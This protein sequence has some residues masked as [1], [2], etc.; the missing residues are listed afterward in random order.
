MML[1]EKEFSMIKEKMDKIDQRLHKLY[2][3]WHA[4]YGNANTIEECEE[5]RNFYK[6][7]LDKYESKYRILYQLLQQPR[8]VLIHGSVSELTPSLTALDDATSLRQ[9]EWIRSELGEDLPRQ[10]SS[11]EGRLTPHTPRS[12][13]MNLEQSLN[14]TPEGSLRDIPTVIQRETLDES[15]ETAYMEFPAI[16]VETTPKESTVPKSLPGTKEAS[17]AEVL[18]STRQFFATVDHRNI[19]VPTVNQTTVAEVHVRDQS[20]LAEIPTTSVVP[21]T[22][23]SVTPL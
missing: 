14:I 1:T 2:K 7:Y 6:P 20:E 21:T 18:A 3:N 23:T 10:Y 22:M 13:D 9:K 11:I 16:H 12:E 15:T 17:R 5:I 8:P 19:N 4:E